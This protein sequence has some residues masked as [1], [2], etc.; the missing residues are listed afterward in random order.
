M[1]IYSLI[2]GINDYAGNV[3]DLGGCHNDATR[4]ANVLQ[5]RFSIPTSNIQ[6]LLSEAATKDNIINGFLNH[7]SQAKSGDTAIFYYSGHGSQEK[8]PAEFWNIESD[9]QN[10]TLVCHD[11]RVGAGDLADKELRFLIS[12]VA[13]NGAKVV[14]LLD[15]CHS[16]NGTRNTLNTDDN[17]PTVSVRMAKQPSS[18][19][20][21][22]DYV[23][24]KTAKQEGWL[25]NL[26]QMPEGKHIMLSGCQDSELSK[27]LNI[28]G[29]RHGAFTHYLCQTLENTQVSLSYQN[30]LRKVKLQVR[31][32]VDKQN[33]SLMSVQ[34]ANTNEIFLGDE[35]QP[36]RLAVF[37]KDNQWWLDAGLIHAMNK[38]DEIA[39]YMETEKQ[40]DNP[41][42]VAITTLAEVQTEKSLIQFKDNAVQQA[43]NINTSYYAKILQQ[44][45]PKLMIAFTGEDAGSIPA[46][47]EMAILDNGKPSSL[48]EETAPVDC[49]YQII[50]KNNRYIITHADDQRPLFSSV[51]GYGAEGARKV[52]RQAEHLARWHNKLSLE[53]T[54]SRIPD[55]IVQLVVKKDGEEIISDEVKLSYQKHHG[56]WQAPEF[57]LELRYD[58]EAEYKKPL[59]CSLLIFNTFDAS[60]DV[61]MD[62]GIWLRPETS[63]ENDAGS[64]NKVHAATSYQVF[65]GEA[66]TA[67]VDDD[68]F[69]QGITQ[70]QDIFKLIVS[71]TPFN[72]NLLIQDALE[73][74]K[75][76]NDDVLAS[77]GS[78]LQSVLDESFKYAHTRKIVRK[79]KSLPDWTSSYLTINTVRPKNAT[80]ISSKS[81]I[82]LGVGIEIEAHD[83][84]ALVSLE[85]SGQA[86]RSAESTSIN[87]VSPS[88]F[89]AS[90]HTAAFT[91]STGR[92]VDSGLDT[93][94]I[95]A[96]SDS[97]LQEKL[98]P[99]S[100]LV[101]KVD[102]AL[103]ESEQ[104]LP[105]VSDGEFFYPVGF[106][107]KADDHTRIIIQGL[108]EVEANTQNDTQGKGLGKTLKVFFQKITYDKLRL[109][110]NDSTRLAIASLNENGEI[111]EQE[112]IKE[113]TESINQANRIL[114]LVHGI[115]GETQ[116]MGGCISS[117]GKDQNSL[118]DAY[119]LV[120]TFDYESLNSSV[121][122]TATILEKKLKAIGLGKE[123]GKQL[124]VIAYDLGGL[125]MRW[126]VEKQ[127]C[128]DGRFNNLVL[129]AVPNKGTPWAALKEQGF[130]LF[131][132]W[133]YGS[134][135]LMLNNL[136]V[137]P[138]G[139]LAVAGM[140][141]LLEAA[142][143]T[144][145]QM[146][147]ESELLKSL[148]TSTRPN[149]SYF[150]I[151]GN[152]Q[153]LMIDMDD[154][155]Q[156]KFSKVFDYLMER[157]KLA[158]F[159][160]L[161]AKLFKQENDFAFDYESMSGLPAS[162]GGESLVAY[163]ECDHFSYFTDENSVKQIRNAL[164]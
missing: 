117:I 52:L 64:V 36:L 48:L 78:E 136:T 139:G 23:F 130:T 17:L 87:K 119:D 137:I 47:T 43:L 18:R 93:L 92:S 157:S 143:N 96:Q 163:V 132:S 140:V 66:V 150:V 13:K 80:A 63:F 28:R 153:N 6:T 154:S 103:R 16:G 41:E 19:R 32:L 122:D 70:T 158:A 53:N 116:A 83:I 22:E 85:S 99:E 120:L 135:T 30:L 60:V 27:E 148:S 159:D 69:K 111:T 144:I 98:K 104:I 61:A 156:N 49:N 97:E 51:K 141:K 42:P 76:E 35:I 58:D 15:C 100:P 7:L 2:V 46:F 106:A 75:P 164:L 110:T 152:T 125:V 72:A 74:Y 127:D 105:Y 81:A 62:N 133:A 123:H 84:N 34:G 118:K 129:V 45:S 9:R 126:M 145:D 14:I 102:K 128:D 134:L 50:A 59:F 33:P 4:V 11:S 26:E 147:P 114:L 142:D 67:T 57:S 3:P 91:F 94:L 90:K 24:Y 44:A 55:D 131:K 39:I 8:T 101:I 68:R 54:R 25:D 109:K 161:T 112:E 89:T 10:E 73:Q 115:A 31:N 5:T 86:S 124:D 20:L 71:E 155:Q 108:P 95:Q 37:T 82:S 29:K 138:V 38:G 121:Q 65:D 88:C 113:S 146:H 56:E 21:I 151:A 1:S 107:E 40:E 77:K 149:T 12:E 160:V 79:S 162:F